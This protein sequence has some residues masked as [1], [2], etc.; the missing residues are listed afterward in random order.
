[1]PES[2]PRG[3]AHAAPGNAALAR[4]GVQG[5]A[6]IVIRFLFNFARFPE[7]PPAERPGAE[8]YDD[9]HRRQISLISDS[10]FN[11]TT[12]TPYRLRTHTRTRG[13]R[14][15]S[16]NC[17]ISRQS[18]PP[19]LTAVGHVHDHCWSLVRRQAA[20]RGTTDDTPG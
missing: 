7:I 13:H 1:M 20:P 9:V 6:L 17:Q 5:L 12:R 3:A 11:F 15:L 10:H 19:Q 14:K 2:G 8:I 4:V 16:A 18:A